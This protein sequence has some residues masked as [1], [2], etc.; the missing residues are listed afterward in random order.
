MMSAHLNELTTYLA[1]REPVLP[2]AV[3][4]RRSAINVAPVSDPLVPAIVP[5]GTRGEWLVMMVDY[6]VH[7][8]NPG[9]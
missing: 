9:I 7:N 1:F 2:S 8:G 5:V 6:T 3:L 4:E